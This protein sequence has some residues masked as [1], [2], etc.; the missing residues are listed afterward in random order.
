MG[1]LLLGKKIFSPL[2]DKNKAC[3]TE[4]KPNLN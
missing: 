2:Y 4:C 3:N 1:D